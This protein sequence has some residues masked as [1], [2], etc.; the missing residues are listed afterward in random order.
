MAT[1]PTTTIPSPDRPTAHYSCLSP[2][3]VADGGRERGGKVL[4]H[5]VLCYVYVCVYL[6][7]SSVV[8]PALLL[9][10]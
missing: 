6:T 10:P 1:T 9:H 4:D 8:D 3:Y 7:L 2:P 5:S